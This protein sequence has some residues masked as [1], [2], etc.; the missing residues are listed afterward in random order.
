MSPLPDEAVLSG[1]FNWKQTLVDGQTFA[2]WA[3]ACEAVRVSS[4][5]TSA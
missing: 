5:H 2:T 3:A 1:I 4:A